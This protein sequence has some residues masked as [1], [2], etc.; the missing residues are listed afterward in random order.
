MANNGT[1]QILGSAT[2]AT[3]LF[4]A[5]SVTGK[6]STLEVNTTAHTVTA[7][8]TTISTFTVTIT[9]SSA[10]PTLSYNGTAISGSALTLEAGTALDESKLTASDVD[11]EYATI[12]ISGAAI[13]A[14]YATVPFPKTDGT[15]YRITNNNSGLAM[16]ADHRD[17]AYQPGHDNYSNYIREKLA[18][19]DEHK[20]EQLWEFEAVDATVSGPSKQFRVKNAVTGAYISSYCPISQTN[21]GAN[22]A[23]AGD[24]TRLQGGNQEPSKIIT[25]TYKAEDA[26]HTKGFYFSNPSSL[27]NGTTYPFY[28]Y[29][30]YV[31]L[32][33]ASQTVASNTVLDN[34]YRWN[35]SEVAPSF[36]ATLPNNYS[37]PQYNINGTNDGYYPAYKAIHNPSATSAYWIEGTNNK[38][39][40]TTFNFYYNGDDQ[41][42]K[43]EYPQYYRRNDLIYDAF[44]EDGSKIVLK[45]M[46]SV[47][48]N[49]TTPYTVWAQN[50]YL[51]K[52]GNL[53]LVGI[54]GD[55]FKFFDC[56]DRTITLRSP[57]DS[58]YNGQ[59][60]YTAMGDSKLQFVAQ[61]SQ[62]TT[63][64]TGN[65]T[66]SY[67]ILA[68]QTGVDV[69]APKFYLLGKADGSS[70]YTVGASTFDN[71]VSMGGGQVVYA[72][73]STTSSVM[74]FMKLSLSGL[75]DSITTGVEKAPAQPQN[76]VYYDLQGR[77]VANP[78]AGIYLVNG[79]KQ[80][81]K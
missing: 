16:E 35:F 64:T 17:D 59:T 18:T 31:S 3:D 75:N 55:K 74:Q 76:K 9:G 27:T 8:Y 62:L 44:S 46:A 25:L 70:S 36:T 10:S 67:Y 11:G 6:T 28:P 50:S 81:V 26:T 14:T 1:I 78:G 7:T 49:G 29:N 34:N 13:T 73:T 52:S 61:N 24:N 42:Y 56:G 68:T 40:N 30:G 53:I 39:S 37:T 71:S 58:Y 79:K 48:I 32:A 41:W 72:R 57:D 4:V 15:W 38:A 43:D 54:P 60:T 51:P 69:S 65:T 33:A 20:E 5:S 23:L 21:R 45:R 19:L 47:G 80:I 63:T 66:T 12:T 22:G 77:R 2:P